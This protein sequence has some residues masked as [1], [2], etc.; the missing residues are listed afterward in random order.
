MTEENISVNLNEEVISLSEK[1][2]EIVVL[3]GSEN[4]TINDV[5][6][7]IDVT[8]IDNSTNLVISDVTE[9]IISEDKTEIIEVGSNS[10]E[11]NVEFSE[12]LVITKEVEID[13]D[14]YAER[15]DFISDTEFYKGWALPG[16]SENSPNWK[17]KHVVVAGD[18]DT[19]TTW[20]DGDILFDNDWSN[21][22]NLTYI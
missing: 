8:L 11:I 2:D 10:E 6:E 16:T 17:I 19:T 14:S 7:T 1:N 20:A 15:V 12:V 4:L 9:S 13:L 21:R 22:V 3:D 5:S 18:N